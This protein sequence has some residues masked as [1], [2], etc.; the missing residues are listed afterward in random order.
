M[1][2]RAVSF[3]ACPSGVTADCWGSRVSGP[4]VAGARPTCAAR[5]PAPRRAP[6]A[7][8][9]RPGS[10]GDPASPPAWSPHPPQRY[11]PAMEALPMDQRQ[12]E[13]LQSRTTPV[14]VDGILSAK[15][16]TMRTRTWAW[17]GFLTVLGLGLAVVAQ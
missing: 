10:R 9:R 6:Q 11:G 12:R 14:R 8:T 5:W 17:G 16:M 13:L 2:A 3:S 1:E 4:P 15:E 7:G